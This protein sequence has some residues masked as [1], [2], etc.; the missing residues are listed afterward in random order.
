MIRRRNLI[1]VLGILALAVLTAHADDFWVKK[2]WTKWSK[3]DC[4][5]ML[6]DSPWSK[7]WAKS[8]SLLSAALPSQ[9]NRNPASDPRNSAGTSTLGSSN[10][11]TSGSGQEGAAGDS[12]LELHYFVELQSALPIRQAMVRRAQFN[13][14]YDQMDAAHKKAFDAQ[15]QSL[16]EATYQDVI[17][18]RV[19]YGSTQQYLERQLATYWKGLPEDGLP[20]DVYLINEKGDHIPPVKFISPKSAEYSFELF[21]PRMQNN[22][23]VIRETDKTFSVQF[24]NPAVGSQKTGSNVPTNPDNPNAVGNTNN[25]ASPSMGRERVLVTYQLN[26][27][28][29]GG[30]PSY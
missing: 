2:D 16:L 7:K 17:D 25:P 28:T 15:V 1:A 12:S 11:G 23:P 18:V 13:N 10:I 8:E 14:N 5:K 30:K 9:Q 21:F 4:N 19:S 26:K 20:V 27:M 6:Q 24:P 3:D 29:V 22:E